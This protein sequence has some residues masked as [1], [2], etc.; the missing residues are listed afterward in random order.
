MA[1]TLFRKHGFR[2]FFYSREETRMHAHVS[3]AE[4]E[5]KF[6]LNPQVQLASSHGLSARQIKQVRLLVE[7][8]R[9]EIIHEW[10][11]YFA[12]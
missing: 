6:W 5:A 8:H 7:Q 1:P 12:A 9:L 3:H 4:G 10:R 11:T 2:F